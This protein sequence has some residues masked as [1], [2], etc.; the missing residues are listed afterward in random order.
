MDLTG[1]TALVTGGTRG[2]GLA[3]AHRL[4]AAGARVVISGRDED[5]GRAAL[6]QLAAG[7]DAALSTGDATS[8]ADAERAVDTVVERFGHLDIVVNNVGGAA[9]F[10]TVADISDDLWHRT[11]SLNLDPALYTTRRALAHLVPQRSGRIINI[12]SMEGRD[13]D[14]G[15]CAYA[16]AKHAL[17]G[18]TRVLAKEVGVHGITA[19]CVCP[20]AVLTDWVR[21]KGP[22]AA[23]VLGTDYTG[24][25]GHFTGRAVTG[26][27]TSPQEV[28]AAVEWLAS[29]GGAGVTAACISVD[30]GSTVL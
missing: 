20:G 25:L 7:D 13:P 11:L 26:R 30:G 29:E 27:L 12:S 23:R 24:L 14:P 21:D 15:L 3:I 22:V 28:A 2:I 8:R 4:L 5:T 18:F 1:Q 9:D 19:N 6:D 16:T 17:I 10:A